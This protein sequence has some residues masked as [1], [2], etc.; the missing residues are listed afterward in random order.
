M[1]HSSRELFDA[2]KNLAIKKSSKT[3]ASSREEGS[4]SR[5]SLVSSTGHSVGHSV[6]PA[7][8]PSGSD[9]GGSKLIVG[10]AGTSIFSTRTQTKSN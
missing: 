8:A 10:A 5:S 3:S 1:I 2:S 7:A 4:A 6:G 9:G